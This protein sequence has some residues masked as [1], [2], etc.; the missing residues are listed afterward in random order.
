[1]T[2]IPAVPAPPA[3]DPSSRVARC[4]ARLAA[5]LA[6]AAERVRRSADDEAVHDLRVSVRRLAA[7]LALWRDVLEPR[8]RARAMRRM[9]RLRRNAGRARELEVHLAA[10]ARRAGEQP[11]VQQL[12]LR[13][14]S[15]SLARE[16]D[17]ARRRLARR[18]AARR[19]ERIVSLLGRAAAGLDPAAEPLAAAAGARRMADA[20]ARARAALATARGREDDAALHD[21]RLAVKKWRYAIEAFES[22]SGFPAGPGAPPPRVLRAAQQALG[23][24]QDE[25]TLKRRLERH[26]ARLLGRDLTAQAAALSPVIAAVEAGRRSAVEAFRRI[27]PLLAPGAVRLET[28]APAAP[29]H[30]EARGPRA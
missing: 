30:A 26:A 2:L 16:R 18:A 7:A 4:L 14:L 15:G 1:M 29:R 3:G 23:A 28:A 5:S 24:V 20:A 9:R 13:E 25:A 12:L 22:G 21:A 6:R 19:V 11:F 8:A 10:L 27:E 17:R